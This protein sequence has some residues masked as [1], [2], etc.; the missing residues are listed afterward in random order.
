MDGVGGRLGMEDADLFR[1]FHHHLYWGGG[2]FHAQPND[3]IFDTTH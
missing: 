3:N 2:G 1:T